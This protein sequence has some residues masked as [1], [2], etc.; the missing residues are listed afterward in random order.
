MREGD[1]VIVT[2]K[3]EDRIGHGN[4][5]T[6][7]TV[8]TLSKESATVLFPSGLIWIGSPKLVFKHQVQQSHESKAD[9]NTIDPSESPDE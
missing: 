4:S 3:I 9:Q 1:V 8:I 5:E 2:A 6:I 7:G